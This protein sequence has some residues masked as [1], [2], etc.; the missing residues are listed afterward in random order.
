MADCELLEGCLFFNDKMPESAGLGAM[1]KRNYCMGDFS[2]CARFVVAKRLGRE[3]VPVNLYPN[4]W[5]RAQGIIT[6]G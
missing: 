6:A 4:M 3:R 2:K 1:Y 5:E